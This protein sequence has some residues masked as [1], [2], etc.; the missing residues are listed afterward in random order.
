MAATQRPITEAALNEPSGLP[1][2]KTTSSWFIYGDLD[3]NIPEAALRL[4]G[5]ACR[6]EERSWSRAHRTS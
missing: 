2:W 6:V 5:D 3:K 4:H 1:A